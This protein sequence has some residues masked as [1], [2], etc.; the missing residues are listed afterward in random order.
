MPAVID[1]KERIRLSYFT[2]HKD[3]FMDI[4]RL[5]DYVM[6]DYEAD[7]HSYADRI[8]AI[9]GIRC[10][11]AGKVDRN[12]LNVKKYYGYFDIKNEN[13]RDEKLYEFW[14]VNGSILVYADEITY[15]PYEDVKCFED[16]ETHLSTG[17]IEPIL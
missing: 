12:T 10:D 16:T 5:I 4:D 7:P 3:K 14:V 13:G 1:V 9:T 17:F 15:I 6:C 2:Q 8:Y 11:L